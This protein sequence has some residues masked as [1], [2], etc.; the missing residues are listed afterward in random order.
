[1]HMHGGD[2]MEKTVEFQGV[3]SWIFFLKNVWMSLRKIK[4]YVNFHW[5][6][7]SSFMLWPPM[8][9][10]LPITKIKDIA[11]HAKVKV[12]SEFTMY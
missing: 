11:V 12:N 3:C 10:S 5:N 2:M 8:L 4:K 6:L 7:V 9:L 1:M